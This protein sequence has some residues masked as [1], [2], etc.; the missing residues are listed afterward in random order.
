V[1][2]EEGVRD[3][4]VDDG[5]AEELQPFVVADS[6]VL[7]LVEPAGVDER[8]AEQLQVADRDAEPAGK[9]GGAIQCAERLSGLRVANAGGRYDECSSM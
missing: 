1:P 4:Q 9:E 2:G 8:L 6:G 7:M 3:R 5:V